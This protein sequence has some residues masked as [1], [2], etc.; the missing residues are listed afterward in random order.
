M[1]TKEIDPSDGET[2]QV[3]INMKIS[4]LAWLDDLTEE[5][6]LRSRSDVLNR[7]LEELMP[8]DD[9]GNLI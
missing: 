9:E 6:G 1:N 2:I 3:A 8:K 4:T 7:L 5:F